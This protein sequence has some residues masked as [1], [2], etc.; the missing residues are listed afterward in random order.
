M[1]AAPG[2]AKLAGVV[3]LCLPVVLFRFLFPLPGAQAPSEA[4]SVLEHLFIVR[5]LGD[6][7]IF[8]LVLGAMSGAI[9]G[10]TFEHSAVPDRG[11]QWAAA[12][13]H[14]P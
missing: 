2:G 11:P 12:D 6:N 3:A 10:W 14:G 1:T 9:S 8:W 7:L 13:G 4:L 5:T